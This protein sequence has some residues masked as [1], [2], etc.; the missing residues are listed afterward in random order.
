MKSSR[1]DR[2]VASDGKILML[3]NSYA[4]LKTNECLVST[5]RQEAA[6]ISFSPPYQSRCL[7]LTALGTGEKFQFPRFRNQEYIQGDPVIQ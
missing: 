6:E 3:R 4:P 5:R 7:V 2:N 1:I